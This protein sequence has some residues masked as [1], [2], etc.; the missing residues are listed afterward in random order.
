LAP[1]YPD[2]DTEVLDAHGQAVHGR[3]LLS[4]VRATYGQGEPTSGPDM[5]GETKA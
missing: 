4:T 2:F 5:P 3:T 1:N